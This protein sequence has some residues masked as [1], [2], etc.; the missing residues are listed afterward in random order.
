MRSD[1]VETPYLKIVAKAPLGMLLCTGPTGSGK[2]TTL[3][4]TLTEI[5]DPTRNVVTI[6][7]PVEYQ[8]DGINQMQVS[9]AGMLVRRRPAGHPAPGPRRHP[10]RRDPRRGDR[11]HRHAGLAHRPLRAVVAARGRRR[12]RGAPVHRHGHRAVPG[13]VVAERRGRPAPAAAHLHGV[14]G[15]RPTRRRRPRCASWSSNRWATSPNAGLKGDGLQR[16]LRH[17]LPGPRR[18]VRAAARSPT[19]SAS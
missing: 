7:D 3:Y 12:G 5:N 11:P 17:R 1:V 18:R 19:P 14:P 15:G 2:T 4:A 6:E 8:F 9:D 13:R 10:R 16:V